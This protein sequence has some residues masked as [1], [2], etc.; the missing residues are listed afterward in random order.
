MFGLRELIPDALAEDLE[1]AT[2]AVGLL[3]AAAFVVWA[4]GSLF[5]WYRTRPRLPRP[6]PA[7][8]ELFAEPPAIANLLVN[9]LNLTSAAVTGTLVDLAARRILALEDYA[10]GN[11]VVRIRSNQPEGERLTAYER[12]VFDLVQRR[13]TGGSAPV[14]A[15]DLGG[16][17]EAKRWWERFRRAVEDDAGGRGLARPRWRGREGAFISFGLLIV[18]MLGALTLTAAGVEESNRT[19]DDDIS[20]WDWPLFALV[21]WAGILA[22]ASRKR[23]LGDTAAGREAA[24]RWLGTRAYLRQSKAFGDVPPGAVAIWERHLAY[25]AAFGLAHGVSEAIPLEADDPNVAWSRRDGQWRELRITYPTRFGWGQKPSSVL[26]EGLWMTALWGFLG[27]IALPMVTNVTWDVG[28][29]L[30]DGDFGENRNVQLFAAGIFVLIAGMGVY[31]AVNFIR[32]VARL[33]LVL[34]DSG[35]TKVL[36]GPVVNVYQGRFAIDDGQSDEVP[37]LFPG[38]ATTVPARGQLVRATVTPRLHYVRALQVVGVE[39]RSEAEPLAVEAAEPTPQELPG[40]ARIPFVGQ[41]LQG[42]LA[43]NLTRAIDAALA[44]APPGQYGEGVRLATLELPP[45]VQQA[46]LTAL[47]QLEAHEIGGYRTVVLAP[48]LVALPGESSMV[49]VRA[50]GEADTDSTTAA[51]KAVERIYG[52]ASAATPGDAAA[53]T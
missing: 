29:D 16:T 40:L 49:L 19:S 7:T 20:R 27:F 43:G 37:A 17:D 50:E 34:A 24:A 26:W 48:G 53:A 35:R 8:Q 41:L 45:A 31:F 36:E 13:A 11:H 47:P 23:L 44:S 51:L 25:A 15:L 1:G 5:I 39:R 33:V 10:G 18:L 21:A 2:L 22:V 52:A 12:Q 30:A 14:Q 9:N 38:A 32:G 28:Q 42:A 46:W 6:G 3:A 4:L